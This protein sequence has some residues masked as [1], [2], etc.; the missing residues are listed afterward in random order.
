MQTLRCKHK[1]AQKL[2]SH[3]SSAWPQ[4]IPR[5]PGSV[6]TW[7][8]SIDWPDGSIEHTLVCPPRLS[9]HTFNSWILSSIYYLRKK[10]NP[11]SLCKNPSSEYSTAALEPISNKLADKTWKLVVQG[12]IFLITK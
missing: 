10:Q 3:I 9:A 4:Q 2:H 7:L 12:T 1:T 5:K 8:R 11:M 6:G